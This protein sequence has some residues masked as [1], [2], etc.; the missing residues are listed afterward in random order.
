MSRDQVGNIYLTKLT[1]N[2]VHIK[3]Y[4]EP[5]K[6]CFPP[7]IG[8]TGGKLRYEKIKVSILA[9]SIDA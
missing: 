3:G 4:H 7:D 2:E 1:E 5:D 6:Y 9:I 8:N